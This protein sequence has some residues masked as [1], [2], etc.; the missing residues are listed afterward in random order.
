MVG[1]V[2]T[3]GIIILIRNGC[4]SVRTGGSVMLP[5]MTLVSDDQSHHLVSGSGPEQQLAFARACRDGDTQGAILTW[6]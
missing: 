1:L 5:W 3:P 6:T 2:V 4:S